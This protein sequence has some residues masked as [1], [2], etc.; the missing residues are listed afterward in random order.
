[1]CLYRCAFSRVSW[2]ME[3]DSRVIEPYTH[4][5]AGFACLGELLS[6]MKPFL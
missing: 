2:R 5:Q 4:S 1:M 3:P 6:N